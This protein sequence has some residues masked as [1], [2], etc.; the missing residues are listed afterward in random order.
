MNNNRFQVQEG[1]RHGALVEEAR[2]LMADDDDVAPAD[3]PQKD[4]ET[5]PKIKMGRIGK[6]KKPTGS[7]ADDG[8][9]AASDN[10]A[11]QIKGLQAVQLSNPS[12]GFNEIDIEFMKKAI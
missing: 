1:G 5:G 11:K 7:K 6:K 12:G 8:S 10:Y 2:K 9:K 4:D 3:A